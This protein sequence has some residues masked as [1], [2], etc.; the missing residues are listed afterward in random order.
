MSQQIRIVLLHDQSLCGE[1]L[2]RL[3]GDEPGFNVVSSCGSPAE[4]LDALRREQADV[5]LIDYDSDAGGLDFVDEL[6]GLSSDARVLMLTTRVQGDAVLRALQKGTSGIFKRQSALSDLVKAIHTVA[7]GELWLDPEVMK[8][9]V[10]AVR[11]GEQRT[12]QPLSIRE[13]SVLKAVAE[14]L[15]NH[16]IA[17]KLQIPESSVKYVVRRLFEKAG[18]KTRSQL[19]RIA[20]EK[21]AQ[22]WLPVL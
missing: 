1:G 19:V 14:G 12:S 4:A 5:V 3:L 6:K 22:D 20:L 13:R 15:T 16:Q 2:G 11:S 7:N 9:V 18:V 10:E 17:V 8:A 21:H